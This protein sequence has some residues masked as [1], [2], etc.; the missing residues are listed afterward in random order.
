M[1]L[2]I[3]FVVLLV[4]LFV[5]GCSKNN[6]ISLQGAAALLVGKAWKLQRTDT[7]YY[8]TAYQQ[9]GE[10]TIVIVDCRNRPNWIFYPDMSMQFY[11]GC[12]QPAPAVERGW[13]WSID[14]EKFV[15]KTL[16]GDPRSGPINILSDSI[17]T[18]TKDS[19]VLAS[20]AHPGF[21]YT[22]VITDRPL[23]I[24]DWYIH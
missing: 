21:L 6:K 3:P 20:W 19:L 18:L 5:S 1:R 7:I 9:T 15:V 24:H 2:S 11:T 8:D 14:L 4:I 10:Q 23:L 13:S 17:V 22:P 12:D 16:S